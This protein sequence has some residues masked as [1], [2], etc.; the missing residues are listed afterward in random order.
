MTTIKA[1]FHS[2]DF[3][4]VCC[5][6]LEQPFQET[7]TRATPACVNKVKNLIQKTNKECKKKFIIALWSLVH[8]LA[9]KSTAKKEYKVPFI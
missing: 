4:Q 8:H 7:P 6:F 2:A 3:L 1:V 9:Y 5:M